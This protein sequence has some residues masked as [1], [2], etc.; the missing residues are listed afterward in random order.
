M[1]PAIVDLPKLAAHYAI[2]SMFQ[3]YPERARIYCYT[4]ERQDYTSHEAGKMK[5]AVG[6]ARFTSEITRESSTLGFGVLYLGG[7]NVTGGVRE[8]V[9]EQAYAA[10]TRELTEAFSR[11]DTPEVIRLLDKDFGK[12]IYSLKS[13]FRDEQ[14]RIISLILESTLKEV[15]TTNRRVYE[16]HVPLMHFLADLGVPQPRIFHLMAEFALNSQIREALEKDNLDVERIHSLLKEA[17]TT[18]IPLDTET[19]EFVL[20]KR[21]ERKAEELGSSPNDLSTLEQ[22]EAIVN[23]AY[24]MPFP[25]NFWQVENLYAQ[26]MDG[27]YSLNR[28]RAEQGDEAARNWIQHFTTL[29]EKLRLRVQ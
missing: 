15:E 13:L 1:K 14:N 4:A 12:N 5:L 28:A 19:L 23:L 21:A 17:A 9:D 22:L 8:F 7:H 27:V 3:S 11:A 16:Q 10:V 18:Q 20:R 2:S 6:R 24:S 29:A 25:V 26:N